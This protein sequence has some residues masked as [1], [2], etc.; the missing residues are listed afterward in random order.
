MVREFKSKY[1]KCIAF[2][3]AEHSKVIEEHL[4]EGE[5]VNY[6]FCGQKSESFFSLFNSCVVAI[7]DQRLVVGQKRILWGSFFTSVTPDLYNDLKVIKNLIWSDIFIDT[8]SEKV[9]I[10]NLDSKS[11]V[12][13]S[14]HI[15]KFMMEEKKKYGKKNN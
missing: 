13:I 5:K 7:T 15:T 3:L 8:V 1:S 10:S 14:K 2:R 12:E 4:Y 6:V 11:A 9:Y